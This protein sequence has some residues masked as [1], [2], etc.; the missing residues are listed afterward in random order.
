MFPLDDLTLN[1]HNYNMYL[2]ILNVYSNVPVSHKC[3]KK[4][5][6]MLGLGLF[7]IFHIYSIEYTVT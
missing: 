1:G 4:I 6:I 2:N 5:R 7:A 3:R